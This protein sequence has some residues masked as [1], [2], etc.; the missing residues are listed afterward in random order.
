MEANI[1]SC[2]ASANPRDRRKHDGTVVENMTA[3]LNGSNPT[4][5]P[6]SVVFRPQHFLK[7]NPIGSVCMYMRQ[8]MRMRFDP[9]VT[10]EEKIRLCRE[11]SGTL[12]LYGSPTR[13]KENEIPVLS[14]QGILCV[15][16]VPGMIQ[17]GRMGEERGRR[18]RWDPGSVA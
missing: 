17:V 1:P 13:A 14:S 8:D 18:G 7:V 9:T 16:S 15:R 3:H 11:S 10:E 2:C 6:M 12:S 5:A 4:R